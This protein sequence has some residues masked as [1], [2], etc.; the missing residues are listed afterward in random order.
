M[1]HILEIGRHPCGPT[2]IVHTVA[3]PGTSNQPKTI[4]PEVTSHPHSFRFFLFL[5][6]RCFLY[7]LDFF[8]AD[9]TQL[10]RPIFHQKKEQR[11]R[12]NDGKR[13]NFEEGHAPPTSGNQAYDYDSCC[14]IA[15]SLPVH[16]HRAG[17]G[18]L[19]WRKPIEHISVAGGKQESLASPQNEPCGNE[20]THALS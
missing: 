12:Y 11:Q 13:G 3:R 16:P 7:H 6:R 9:Q 8:T 19:F 1:A 4:V 17:C 15:K 14:N 2:K 20:R 10:S 18:A 5:Y